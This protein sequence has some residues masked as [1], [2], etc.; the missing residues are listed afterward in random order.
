M[1]ICGRICKR[2]IFPVLFPRSSL[3]GGTP[4][5]E[6]Q[7]ATL[8][9]TRSPLW[10]GWALDASFW[11]LG[12]AI[13]N[14]RGTRHHEQG[15][16]DRLFQ[17]EYA[18]PGGGGKQAE[19]RCQPLARAMDMGARKILLSVLSP[20]I[21]GHPTLPSL[22]RTRGGARKRT[23]E[24]RRNI[25]SGSR[26]S[27]PET[28]S[29]DHM[30]DLG[31]DQVGKGPESH[32]AQGPGCLDRRSSSSPSIHCQPFVGVSFTPQ[33]PPWWAGAS[34]R[35]SRETPWNVA[36]EPGFLSYPATSLWDPGH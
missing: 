35:A 27:R 9:I 22:Y 24:M 11:A 2:I 5:F 1:P 7:R 6:K 23:K 15:G 25:I 32:E 33:A 29:P 30:K 31:G 36:G 17:Q 12:P 18:W 14:W 13:G 8:E 10:L 26:L 28:T 4:L 21:L 34:L 20:G 3:V 16:S 19:N